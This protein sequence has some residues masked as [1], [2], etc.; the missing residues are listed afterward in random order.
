ML[1]SLESVL[2]ADVRELAKIDG[3]AENAAYKIRFLGDF[4][5]YSE[6]PHTENIIL[7]SPGDVEKYFGGIS[8]GEREFG[9][10][11]FLD[12]R[13]RLVHTYAIRDSFYD[14]L[15][16]GVREIALKAVISQCEY[17]IMAHT[18]PETAALASSADISSTNRLATALKT[19]GVTLEDH[20][21]I[22]GESMLSMRE[23][24][25]LKMS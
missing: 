23:S 15:E 24:G 6:L 16:F 2:S 10:A 19:I 13:H 12:S 21:I 22:G 11:L 4:F 8:V 9:A 17:V 1:G 20:I 7:E 5:R 18:H 3:I 25:L 14:F